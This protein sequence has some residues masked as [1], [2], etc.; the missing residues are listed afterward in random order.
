MSNCEI[1]GS[2]FKSALFGRPPKYCKECAKEKEKIRAREY[3]K[4]HR[5][6]Y[7]DANTK[8][9]KEWH[10]ANPKKIRENNRSYQKT[11]KFR[12]S[13]KK[14][15]EKNQEK[16]KERIKR[17]KINHPEKC[18]V[19]SRKRRAFKNNVIHSFTQNQ[20]EIKL[21]KTLPYLVPTIDLP[22]QKS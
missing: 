19:S 9:I 10:K 4:N 17:W 7:P 18:R 14:Y 13:C 8:L 12:E 20:W 15:R 1:C 5:K 6:K 11:E 2:Y 16:C 21:N 3:S 22:Y